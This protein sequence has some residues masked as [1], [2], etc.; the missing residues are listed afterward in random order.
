MNRQL[1]LLLFITIILSAFTTSAF[2]ADWQVMEDWPTTMYQIDKETVRFSGEDTDK[3]LEVWMKSIEKDK[4]GFYNVGHYLVKENGLKFI[5]KDRIFYS[6]NGVIGTPFKNETD[7][8]SAT[9]LKSPIGAV[10]TRLF[11]EYR[12]NPESF[13]ITAPNN[14]PEGVGPVATEEKIAEIVVDPNELKKALD[15]EE[16]KENKNGIGSKDF[17]V[18][19]RRG[20]ALFSGITH[21]VTSDFCLSID[22]NGKRTTLLKFSTEDTRTGVHQ[23]KQGILVLVDGNEWALTPS[24]SDSNGTS[25]ANYRYTFKLPNQLVQ[26]ISTT[27][28]PVTIKW[29][30]RYNNVWEDRERIIPDKKLRAIQLMYLGC[31]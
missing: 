2:A 14:S 5:L 27:K 25:S 23:E 10:A 17:F 3:Q 12:K 26:A 1:A 24:Y 4:P 6:G 30:H 31:K 22:A 7:N 21:Y 8:W 20:P 11:A 16:I 28:D 13:N 29:K 18:R 19:D 9:T 15:D